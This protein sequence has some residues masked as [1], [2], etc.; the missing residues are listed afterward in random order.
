MPR[1]CEFNGI[2]IYMYHSEHAP[3]HF[4]ALYAQF[5]AEF[6]IRNPQKVDGFMPLRQ[7]RL[8]QQWAKLHT[9]ELIANWDRARR[10]DVLSR[11]APLA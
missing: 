3:P 11:I 10:F 5:K 2:E 4:H 6:E 1:I 7:R 9:D 8:V